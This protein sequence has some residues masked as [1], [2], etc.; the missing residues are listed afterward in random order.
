MQD[1]F[2]L[3]SSTIFLELMGKD[4]PD[5]LRFL[6]SPRCTKALQNDQELLAWARAEIGEAPAQLSRLRDLL[7][8][9]REVLLAAAQTGK[10]GREES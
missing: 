1:L 9:T 3:A 6:L 8:T 10:T 4:E 7:A 2:R 5:F